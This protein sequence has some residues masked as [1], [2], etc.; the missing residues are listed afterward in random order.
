V[1]LNGKPPPDPRWTITQ[2]GRNAINDYDHCVCDVKLMGVILACPDCGTVY[3]SIKDMKRPRATRWTAA[4][5][6]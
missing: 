2:Q 3:G 4:R 5:R 6:S 1:S